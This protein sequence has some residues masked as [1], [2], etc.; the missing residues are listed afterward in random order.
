MSV[1]VLHSKQ[2]EL[3]VK[4]DIRTKAIQVAYRMTLSPHEW[5]WNQDEQEA[6]AQF[7]LWAHQRIDAYRQL[8]SEAQLKHEQ[9]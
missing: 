4:L 6:M 8:G 2:T 9:E 1:I 5:T 7:V 3:N